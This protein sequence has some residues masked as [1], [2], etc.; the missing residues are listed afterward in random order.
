MGP[1]PH[2]VIHTNRNGNDMNRPTN[3]A[4]QPHNGVVRSDCIVALLN[5]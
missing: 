4:V 1:L 2:G 3:N 5:H